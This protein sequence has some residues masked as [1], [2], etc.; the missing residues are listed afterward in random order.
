MNPWQYLRR[1]VDGA[2]RS[3]RY[4][5]SAK[6]VKRT[7]RRAG[8]YATVPA[9]VKDRRRFY[10]VAAAVLLPVAGASGY[11]AVTSGFDALFPGDGAPNGLPATSPDRQSPS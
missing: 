6:R 5:L 8:R 4:D 2:I 11:F 7:G 9:T 1:E 10:A 3:I